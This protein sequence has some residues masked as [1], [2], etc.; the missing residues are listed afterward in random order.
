MRSPTR[1]LGTRSR[2]YAHA[3]IHTSPALSR[4]RWP[5]FM[6]L[7]AGPEGRKTGWTGP[8]LFPPL[9]PDVLAKDIPLIN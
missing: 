1:Y 4:Q 3:I 5:L 2:S 8:S 7:I 6:Q 9:A